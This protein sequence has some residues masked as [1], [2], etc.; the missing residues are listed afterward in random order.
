M[1][2]QQLDQHETLDKYITLILQERHILNRLC[3]KSHSQHRRADYFQRLQNVSHNTECSYITSL[4]SGNT[5]TQVKR[6]LQYIGWKEMVDV[7]KSG[8]RA[9]SSLSSQ[10][11]LGYIP[12]KTLAEIKPSIELVLS[13]CTVILELLD[14]TIEHCEMAFRA[15]GQ[16]LKMKYFTPFSLTAQALCS[17]LAALAQLILEYVIRLHHQLQL[18]YLQQ[19]VRTNPLYAPKLNSNFA[20]YGRPIHRIVQK[21]VCAHKPKDELS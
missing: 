12:W 3:Y 1:A 2:T 20:R 10:E 6:D 21:R 7:L 4:I 14:R 9:L 8:N 13:Q 17:R 16:Q 19:V 18:R 11:A 15:L 5:S